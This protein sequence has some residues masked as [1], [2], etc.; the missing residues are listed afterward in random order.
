MWIVPDEKTGEVVGEADVVHLGWGY[1]RA[2]LDTHTA[3]DPRVNG[4]GQC[5]YTKEVI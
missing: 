5:E 4:G 3:I 2:S 1:E